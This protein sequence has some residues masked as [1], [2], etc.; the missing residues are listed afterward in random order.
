L[1]QL[2]LPE[3]E[4]LTAERFDAVCKLHYA[5]G[6]NIGIM[7][8]FLKAAAIHAILMG[9]PAITTEHLATVFGSMQLAKVLPLQGNGELR[10]NP[11]W[12]GFTFPVRSPYFGIKTLD[13]LVAKRDAAT[14]V[15]HA[16]GTTPE[17]EAAG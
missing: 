8:E 9:A 4:E 11:Y 14:P 10:P 2:P 5:T 6:G 7:V 3:Q 15:T 17:Q 13:D 16:V 12:E 1:K